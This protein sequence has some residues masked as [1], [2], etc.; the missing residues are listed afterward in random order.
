MASETRLLQFRV[1]TEN[2]GN[3]PSARLLQFFDSVE[4]VSNYNTG[5]KDAPLCIIAKVKHQRPLSEYEEIDALRLISIFSEGK[6]ES[7]A[8]VTLGGPI[9]TLVASLDGIWFTKPS[10]LTPANI[11]VTLCGIPSSIKEVMRS[12]QALPERITY[13]LLEPEDATT[14][15]NTLNQMPIRRKQVLLKAIE[16]GY[17][18]YPR[19]CTQRDIAKA[20]ELKQAT[21]SEH[22]QK[23][24]STVLNT[25]SK[26]YH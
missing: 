2:F 12:A 22:L 13:S 4:F 19:G 20:V 18:R 7:L 24:E 5:S 25:W 23:G 1:D 10:I 21:V 17:Y 9:P 16:L 6:D 8:I 26:N 14:I 3:L 15:S 11:T